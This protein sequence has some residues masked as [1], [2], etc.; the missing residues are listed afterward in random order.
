[1]TV[2]AIT[3]EAAVRPSFTPYL[4]VYDPGV[5]LERHHDRPVCRWNLD[6]IVG[7]D[8][9]RRG[10]HPAGATTAVASLHDGAPRRP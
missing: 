7:G 8:R 3:R 10:P 5:I 6:L 2:G 1:M 9:H 4:R